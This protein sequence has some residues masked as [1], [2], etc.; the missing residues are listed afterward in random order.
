M[1][2][3]AEVDISFVGEGGKKKEG[4]VA[5]ISLLIRIIRLIKL[6]QESQHPIIIQHVS[7]YFSYPTTNLNVQ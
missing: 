4:E 6:Y 1:L 2:E 5:L 7:K 3:A